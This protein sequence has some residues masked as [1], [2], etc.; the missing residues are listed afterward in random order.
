MQSEPPPI[1]DDLN[2][3]LEE[4]APPYKR[5][6]RGMFVTGIVLT[7]IG[8][9]AL[10][11]AVL[12]GERQHCSYTSGQTS[13]TTRPNY[14]AWVA[15]GLLLGAGIPMLAVGGQKVPNRPA[16]RAALTPW[17]SPYSAGLSLQLA[18]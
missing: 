13:C 5:R 9:L 15:T 16:P 6:N 1:R 10:A 14:E 8:T 17:L 7:S 3:P 4:G 2:P 11:V 18:L 12:S